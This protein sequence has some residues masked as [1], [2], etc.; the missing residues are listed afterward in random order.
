[1]GPRLP[2]DATPLAL[3]GHGLGRASLAPI[4]GSSAQLLP[5]EGQHPVARDPRGVPGLFEEVLRDDGVG[6]LRH[7]RGVPGGGVDLDGLERGAKGLA[8]VGEPLG[9]HGQI[10]GEPH[11]EH[12]QA[13][14]GPRP[15]SSPCSPRASA[16]SHSVIRLAWRAASTWNS[17]LTQA[18][19]IW[20]TG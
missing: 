15:P 6:V 14:A 11:P 3:P 7:S 4:S 19:A 13:V 18:L 10:A 9:G 12:P 17:R 5:K 8:Q 2:Q 16:R 1:M 20:A